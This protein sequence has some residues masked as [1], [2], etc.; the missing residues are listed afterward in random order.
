MYF[1]SDIGLVSLLGNSLA[2]HVFRRREINVP[3]TLLLNI[4]VVDL[5]LAV[6]SHPAVVVGSFSHRWVLG[7]IGLS[8]NVFISSSFVYCQYVKVYFLYRHH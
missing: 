4:A 5:F 3:E 6:A 1:L 7:E 8:Q 2:V